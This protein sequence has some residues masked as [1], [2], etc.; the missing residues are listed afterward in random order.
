[1]IFTREPII[2]TIISARDGFK[3]LVRNSKGGETEEYL[4]D[5]LEVVSFGQA[6]FLRSL[7]RPKSFLVPA[8]D[9]EVV[10]V[11][12]ARATL[13]NISHEK[14]IKIGGG[15]EAS[16]RGNHSSAE[17]EPAEVPQASSEE[18]T[19]SQ[20]GNSSQSGREPRSDR[21]R[22]RRRHRRRRGDEQWQKEAPSGTPSA[23]TSAEEA[24]KVAVPAFTG[25]IP[26]PPALI[27][28]TLSR[29]KG[30][31]FF[32]KDNKEKS[33][34]DLPKEEPPQDNSGGESVAMSKVS[35]QAESATI[36]STHFLSPPGLDPFF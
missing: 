3:L 1:M 32:A 27:S 24:P 36:T 15:K 9:Y 20:E 5:A 26:P 33:K 4:V 8:T 7:E 11:K 30:Q 23:E 28:E 10:E 16:I 21:R 34:E 17:K 19:A 14:T 29:Y 35:V 31:E 12:E 22:D 6:F 18:E 25:L 2:E 13:K